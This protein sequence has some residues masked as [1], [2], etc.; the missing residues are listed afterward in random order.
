MNEPTI[1]MTAEIMS[2]YRRP[3][4]SEIGNIAS[5]PKKHPAWKAETILAL[6]PAKSEADLSVNPKALLNPGRAKVPPMTPV[7]YPNMTAPM[8]AQNV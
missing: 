1:K 5:A 7:S 2:A 8:D 4:F 3:I 6:I